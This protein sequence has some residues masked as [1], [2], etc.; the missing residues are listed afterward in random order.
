MSPLLNFSFLIVLLVLPSVGWTIS[1]PVE[2][3]KLVDCPATLL[4]S[5]TG[6]V[7]PNASEQKIKCSRSLERH[8]RFRLCAIAK[9]SILVRDGRRKSQYCLMGEVPL[10]RS[11]NDQRKYFAPIACTNTFSEGAN[12]SLFTNTCDDVPIWTNEEGPSDIQAL[13]T[14][15]LL[16]L[17]KRL[18]LQNGVD[19]PTIFRGDSQ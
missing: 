4:G 11:A 6:L 19:E 1:Q 12:F 3:D 17:E 10:T 8:F 14:L 16:M 18:C 2:V 13:A 15:K 9:N 5:P 7:D